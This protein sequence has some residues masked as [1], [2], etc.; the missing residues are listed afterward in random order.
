MTN[1]PTDPVDVGGRGREVNDLSVHAVG[2]SVHL[3]QRVARRDAIAHKGEINHPVVPEEG[4]GGVQHRHLDML[5]PGTT[6]T[7]E[8]G[9]RHGLSCRQGGGFVGH[10]VAHQVGKRDVRIDL[11]GDHA[12]EPL[13]HRV[14]Y[15]TIG[16]R[17]VRS[18]ATD[19]HVDDVGIYGAHVFVAKPQTIA[20]ARTEVLD[21]HVGG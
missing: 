8:Q 15:G 9:R 5:A 6:F 18:V 11:V 3:G 10:D 16:I 4:Q 7:G 21:E 12:G 2:Q 1:R 20:G 19:R 13:D 17:A 14:Q